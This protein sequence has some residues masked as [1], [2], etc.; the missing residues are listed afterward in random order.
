MNDDTVLRSC[1]RPSSKPSVLGRPVAPPPASAARAAGQPA[2]PASLSSF[3]AGILKL[4]DK[5]SRQRRRSELL[6]YYNTKLSTGHTMNIKAV[7]HAVQHQAH[8][9]TIVRK[10][11]K[12]SSDSNSNIG[13]QRLTYEYCCTRFLKPW[14]T[15]II[16]ILEFS[17]DL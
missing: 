10:A 7:I 2:R 9:T 13:D 16:M 12:F 3:H 4:K 6:S 15:I 8:K 14:N 5:E 11:T 1:R 17:D